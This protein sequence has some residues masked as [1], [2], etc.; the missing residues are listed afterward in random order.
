MGRQHCAATIVTPQPH[1]KMITTPS[2]NTPQREWTTSVR[3]RVLT[4]LSTGFSQSQMSRDTGVAHSTVVN[5][6]RAPHYRRSQTRIGR[7]HQLTNMISGGYLLLLGVVGK[8][9]RCARRSWNAVNVDV[10][11]STI[12]RALAKAEYT[13]CKVCKRPFIS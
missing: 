3:V 13:G 9:E 6:S 2:R 1:Q 12:Q 10:H 7:P 11:R 5:W 4:L 8:E